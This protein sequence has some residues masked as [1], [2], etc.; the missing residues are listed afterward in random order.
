MGGLRHGRRRVGLPV[1][2]LVVAFVVFASVATTAAPASAA[3]VALRPPVVDRDAPDPTVVRVDDTYY[4]F[5]TNVG[6][7]GGIANVPVSRSS[8]LTN[9]TLI[10]EALPTLGSWAA[11]GFTWAPSVTQ[12]AGKWVLYYTALD[13]ASGRECIGVALANQ[14]IG[15][16]VDSRGAPLVC[17]LDHGGSIDPSPYRNAQGQWWLTWKSDDNAIGGTPGIWSQPLAANGQSLTGS[18]TV[19]LIA[20]RAWETGIVEAPVFLDAAN[21][22]WLFYS[23]GPYASVRYAAGYGVCAGPSGPCTKQTIDGPWL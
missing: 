6:L 7:F 9:W 17:Q 13:A 5:T 12:I 15:P 11:V 18:P 21:K 19:L 14:V 4:S 10:A 20:D 22:L 16:Y 8:D 3:T 2:A 23:A 1:A